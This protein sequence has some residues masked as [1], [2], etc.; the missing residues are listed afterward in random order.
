MDQST[1][2]EILIMFD[3]NVDPASIAEELSISVTTVRTT[4]KAQGRELVRSK[5]HPEETNIVNAYVLGDP[6]VQIREKFNITHT[7]LYT[8]LARNDVEIRKISEAEGKGNA[9]DHAVDMYIA[10][11]PIW[12]IIQQTGVNQPTL[13]S[14]LHV[15]GVAFRRP[16]KS[17]LR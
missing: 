9:M 3:S 10:G 6:V 7:M 13:H 4:L 14:E 17:G 5:R 16:R 12:E 15:R 2:S 8:I 11:N 1:I